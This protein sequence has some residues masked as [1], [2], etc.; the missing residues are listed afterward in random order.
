MIFIKYKDKDG[1]LH[2]IIASGLGDLGWQLDSMG[3]DTAAED[4]NYEI[5]EFTLKGNSL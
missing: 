4:D 5:V 3:C 1:Q 2:E